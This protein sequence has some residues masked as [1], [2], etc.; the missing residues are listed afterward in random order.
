MHLYTYPELVLLSEQ[1][2]SSDGHVFTPVDL[3]KGFVWVW[4]DEQQL[5]KGLWQSWQKS[6]QVASKKAGVVSPKVMDYFHATKHLSK[7]P[8]EGDTSLL[9]A[10]LEPVLVK[11]PTKPLFATS[12]TGMTTFE[13]CPYR[14]AQE[15]W[16]KTVPY[17]ESEAAKWGNRVHTAFE[18][19]LKGTPNA[20]DT[21]ILNDHGWMKY[22]QAMLKAE[23]ELS[24]ERELC[25]TE[26]LNLCGWKDWNTVWFRLKADI[27]LKKGAVLKYFDLK[28]GK[29]K[30]DPFQIEVT[31]AVAAQHFPDT[32]EFDGR[33]IFLKENSVWGPGVL[34]RED[35]PRIWEKILAI[36]NRM[37]E[38]V[39]HENFRMQSSGLCRQYC[40]CTTCPHCGRGK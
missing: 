27:L 36:T 13:Q 22:A 24:A 35:L 9:G 33:L 21:K 1:V 15:K 16:Y 8:A 34:T 32:E 23:G 37:K 18:R 4:E 6:V 31:W 30:E 7:P 12:Y 2:T 38:A 11:T 5:P 39:K 10:K 40:G 3:R 25:L 29:R 14:W 26:D 19:T 17:E 28:S 20:E